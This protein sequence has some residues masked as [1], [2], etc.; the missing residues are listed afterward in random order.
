[1]PVGLYVDMGVPYLMG[2]CFAL[3]LTFVLEAGNFS[4]ELLMKVLATFDKILIESCEAEHGR[5]S[6]VLDIR[7][8]GRSG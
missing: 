5:D 7:R 1:M 4:F 2:G 6:P 3:S 8:G